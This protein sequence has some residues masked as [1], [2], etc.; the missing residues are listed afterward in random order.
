MDKQIREAAA[1]IG[2]SRRLLVF[3]GAGISAESGIPT[4]RDAGGFWNEFPPEEYA[5]WRGLV[6]IAAT[7]SKD[8]AHFLH[9]VIAPIAAARPNAAHKAIGEAEAQLKITV[10]TQNVDGLHQE[11]GSTTVHEIHGTLMETVTESGRFHSLLSR[12]DL[13]RIAARLER[14]GKGTLS[15]PRILWAVRPLAGIGIHGTYRPKVVLFNDAMSEPAWSQAQ[16][17]AEEADC[18]LQIGCSNA[19]YPAAL[20]PSI[21]KD[22]GADVIA[23]DPNHAI[24]DIWLRGTATEVVPVLLR[25]ATT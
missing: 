20:L 19:V 1:M 7:R 24:S 2:A 12:Q 9:A 4:F 25:E 21:A 18:V 8:V 17:A 3:T 16:Q 11:A 13:Q 23:V 5:N 14:A 22:N 10:V 6:A 15:L